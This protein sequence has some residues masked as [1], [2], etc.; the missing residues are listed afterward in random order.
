ML[1]RSRAA[2]TDSLQLFMYPDIRLD[3]RWMQQLW[4]PILPSTS[5]AAEIFRVFTKHPVMS[6][7]ALLQSSNT[8]AYCLQK[9]TLGVS[10]S[11]L[12]HHMTKVPAAHWRIFIDAI[13]AGLNA[14]WVPRCHRTRT[15]IVVVQRKKSRRLLNAE[16]IA[17]AARTV[18]D[19]SA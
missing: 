11:K 14:R 8:Q 15:N 19:N 13:A 16:E 18:F 1:F 12:D 7:P 9:L 17:D 4:E 3:Q 5:T 6:L 10:R 2:L